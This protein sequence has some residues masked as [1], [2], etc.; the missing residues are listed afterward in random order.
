MVEAHAHATQSS[1]LQA[2]VLELLALI[3]PAQQP[4][5]ARIT[6]RQP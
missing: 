2:A 5:A 1:D 6:R 4:F 3:T